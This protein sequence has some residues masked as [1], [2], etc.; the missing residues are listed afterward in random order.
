MLLN[1]N[2]QEGH[3]IPHKQGHGQESNKNSNVDFKL[4]TSTPNHRQSMWPITHERP[5]IL[6]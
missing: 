5:F 6:S 4:N 3:L 1:R 2:A